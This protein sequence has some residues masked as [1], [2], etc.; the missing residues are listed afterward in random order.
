ML[1]NDGDYTIYQIEEYQS[2]WDRW[3]R[4]HDGNY[5]KEYKFCEYSSC[6]P[7][8][9][10]TGQR[11]TFSLEFAS[12]YCNDLNAG[13]RNGLIKSGTGEVQGFRI[14]VCTVSQKREPLIP[15]KY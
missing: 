14:L 11:G 3:V 15:D 13:L 10:I 6:G 9:Q 7:C 8:W 1:R 2:T 12:K 5:L 4:I